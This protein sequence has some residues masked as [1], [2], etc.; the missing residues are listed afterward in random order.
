M[1]SKQMDFTSTVELEPNLD[2]PLNQSASSNSETTWCYGVVLWFL[3]GFTERFCGEK[4]VILSTSPYGPS[5]H[6][7]QTILTFQDPIALTLNAGRASKLGTV[8]TEDSPAVKIQ[9]RISIVRAIQHR[10]IDISL[11]LTG[12]G[13]DGRKHSWPAQMFNLK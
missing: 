4:P 6:W 5:T 11:E 7:S 3:T 12:I 2:A 1:Q 8:G 10:S 9:S 13:P